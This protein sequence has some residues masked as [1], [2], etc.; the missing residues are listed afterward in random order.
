MAQEQQD[1]PSFLASLLNAGDHT[2][3]S[4][5]IVRTTLVEKILEML[6][7]GRMA[8]NLSNKLREDIFEGK[9]APLGTLS[10]KIDLACAFG[11]ITTE[12]RTTLNNIRKVPNTF[13]HAGVIIH[14]S[15]EEFKSHKS[16]RG[17][18][19]GVSEEAFTAAVRDFVQ[20]VTP[21]L[22]NITLVKAIRAHRG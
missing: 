4:R 5:V 1:R 2:Q 6:L 7:E 21:Q 8:E 15:H 17:N 10:A 18:P 22:E 13:A 12:Q 16:I 9:N 20:E 3:F 19:L 11:L 14:F